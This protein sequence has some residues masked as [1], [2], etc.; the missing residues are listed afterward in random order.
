MDSV[1]ITWLGH[2]CFA[3]SAEGYTIVLDPYENNSVAGLA[4]IDMTANEVLCSHFHRD[5]GAAN[6]IK[7]LTDEKKSPFTVEKIDSYHD[8]AQGTKRGANVVHKISYNGITVVHFGDIGCMPGEDMCGRIENADAVMIPVGGFFTID[9]QTA[10]KI[11]DMINAR[12]V[13]PMHF[14]SENAGNSVI[15]GLGEFTKL[16]GNVKIYEHNFINID[17][18]TEKQ[19]AVLKYK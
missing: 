5:H 9:A 16:C 2:A 14:A 7:L 11:V 13:L 12:V 6:V 15:A 3:V 17:K 18:D 4:P 1:K 10:K 8:D 19:T